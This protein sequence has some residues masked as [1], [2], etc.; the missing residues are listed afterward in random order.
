MGAGAQGWGGAEGEADSPPSREPDKEFDLRTLRSPPESKSRAGCWVPAPPGALWPPL[1]R[2]SCLQGHVRSCGD[3]VPSARPAGCDPCG[4]TSSMG[5]LDRH[6]FPELGG[7]S[8]QRLC[9]CTQTHVLFVDVTMRL[10]RCLSRSRTL[11]LM[12]VTTGF[13]AVATFVLRLDAHPCGGARAGALRT[14]VHHPGQAIFPGK[15][16]SPQRFSRWREG[17]TLREARASCFLTQTRGSPRARVASN[18]CSLLLPEPFPGELAFCPFSAACVLA[19]GGGA[20]SP[21]EG[22][23]SESV[24]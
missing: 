16:R 9:H 2:A 14:P 12:V 17:P 21:S 4:P 11:K 18:Q 1:F 15:G 5:I 3:P 7:L 6:R 23:L 19:G 8:E 20:L 10:S 22:L 24:L 13:P